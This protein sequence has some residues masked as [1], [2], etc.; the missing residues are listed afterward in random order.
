MESKK[1]LVT[2]GAGFIGSNFVRYMLNRSKAAIINL[3]KLTY[4]GNTANLKDVENDPRY[5]FVKGDICDKKLVF[6]LTK[7]CHAII[8]FAAESITGDTYLPIWTTLGIKIYSFE[9]L[10]INLSRRNKVK[11]NK[12]AIEAVN[13]KNTNI[14]ALAYKGG[15]GYWMPIKQISRHRYKGK[16]IHL[17]QKWGEIETTPNHSIYDINFCIASPK[18]NPE[19]LGLRNI[20]HISKKQKYKSFT[21]RRLRALVSILGA[22]VSEGWSSFNKANGSHQVGIANKNIEWVTSLKNELRR[23][24][25]NPSVTMTKDGIYQLVVAN[26]EFFKFVRKEAGYTHHCKKI[27]NFIFDLNRPYQEE[28]LKNIVFGD[29]EIIKNKNYKTVRYSTT[30]KRL[31]T[32]LSFLLSLL[33]YN[34]SV[35]KDKRSNAYSLNFGGDYTISLLNKDYKTRNYDGYVYDISIKG[36]HNFVCGIG[37]IVVHNTHVDRSIKDSTEFIRT[38][39]FGTK[40]L[41]EVARENRVRRII[42]VSTDEVYGSI[43]SGKFDENSVIK[44]N[45]PY[46]ASK[47]AGDLLARSYYVTF[48]TPVIIIRSSNNFGP[49][50]YPEKII[51]LFV[52]NALENRKLPLYADGKNVR[53][54]LYVEDNC[55]AI[56]FVLSH[57]REGE[58]YNVGSGNELKNINLTKKILRILGKDKSLIKYVKDRPGHDK[59]YALS[60]S[61]IRRLGWKP[62]HNFDEALRHTV[63]WYKENAKWWK[64]LKKRKEEKFW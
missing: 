21:G 3:D 6:K 42:Q 33:K 49:Y 62:R 48:K 60:A 16:I 22:Y 4:S 27:P 20:N 45:S 12:N 36:L 13:L 59:R 55:D 34:Y 11:I 14:K 63:L 17:R 53:E 41:L 50:Q 40:V 39:V 23:L 28:F 25:Y 51:P 24:G 54:W 52:T 56:N 31:A 57:G 30:S 26:K 43:K 18:S 46:A 8:N 35:I 1:I 2:G 38:N 9:E 47:A 44:P 64:K 61:K 7:G 10:F 15:I 5:T 58:I 32:G 37:N 19:L 29:G